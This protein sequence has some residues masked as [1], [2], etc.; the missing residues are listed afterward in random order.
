MTMDPDG[1]KI[2]I[3]DATYCGGGG[4][5]GDRCNAI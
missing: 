2:Q 1:I 3:Q 4:P 5:L